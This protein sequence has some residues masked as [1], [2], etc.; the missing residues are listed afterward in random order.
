MSAQAWTVAIVY[1]LLCIIGVI[2]AIKA[3][4]FTA[5]YVIGLLVTLL[6]IGL[7]TYDTACLTAGNCGIWSWIRTILYILSPVIAISLFVISFF[8]EK[9]SS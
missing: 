3:G 1:I 9:K 7:L 8:T 4:K 6:F 2:A 5:S